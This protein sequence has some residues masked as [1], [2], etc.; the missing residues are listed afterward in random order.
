MVFLGFTDDVLDLRWRHKLTLPT[1]ASL[2]LLMVYY[3][4]ISNT[5]IIVPKPL[6]FYIGGEVD[7]GKMLFLVCWR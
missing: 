6:R 5:L 1:V 7:L 4:N 3:T 2:P